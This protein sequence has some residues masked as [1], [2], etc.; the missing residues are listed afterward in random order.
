[1]EKIDIHATAESRADAGSVFALL[2]DGATWPKWS[3]FNKFE[4]EQRGSP[5]PLGVGAIR[6][7]VTS[8]S[9]AREQVVELIPSRRLSYILLSGFPFRD[10]RADVDLEPLAAGG[11]LIHWH[12]TFYA[13]H[14]GTGWFWRLFMRRAIRDV[15]AK[16]AKAAENPEIVATCA[17]PP[18]YVMSRQSKSDQRA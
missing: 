17:D 7:F 1:M 16:L 5:D 2:R 12:S 9:R 18:P 11:T 3:L 6:V 13:K 8:V 4:L 14:V 15:A 10:Y